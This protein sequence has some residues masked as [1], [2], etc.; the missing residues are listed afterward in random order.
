MTNY[1]TIV[2]KGIKFNVEFQYEEFEAQTLEHQGQ[3]AH[4]SEI[5]EFK[6]K[7][8]CF[9]QFIENCEDDIIQLILQ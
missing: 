2:W 4:I 1:K 6:H 5:T 7:G 8:E 3:P 9:L